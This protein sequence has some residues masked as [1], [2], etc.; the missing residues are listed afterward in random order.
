MVIKVFDLDGTLT[1]TKEEV[2]IDP[3]GMGTFSFWDLITGMLVKNYDLFHKEATNWKKNTV[4]KEKDKI[5][6][7]KKMTEKGIEFF[8]PENRSAKVVEKTAY[9]ITLKLHENGLLRSDAIYY[10]ADCLQKGEKCV[11]STASYAD[12][13]QGFLKAIFNLGLLPSN[14]PGKL[15]VS[16]NIID[17]KSGRVL[18]MNA[19][20]GKIKGLEITMREPLH[21]FKN[22]IAAVFGDD[23]YIN[24]KAI[25]ELG[26]LSFT[27]PTPKYG[28]S[29]LPH[30]CVRAS[31]EDILEN[32]E[33]LSTLHFEK[34]KAMIREPLESGMMVFFERPRLKRSLSQIHI[35][36]R[37]ADTL[38]SS[39][40]FTNFLMR[41]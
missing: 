17:W 24:D 38:Y 35:P 21:C 34:K 32:K 36:S 25:L 20:Y 9:N 13:A 40:S 26:A 31:W 3:F 12:G 39:D 8:Y 23:P 6:S 28:T 18:H 4:V 16:G 37:E 22:Q 33:C 14:H 10:L 30:N 27:I 15:I 7:S 11:I 29:K 19:E 41:K 1:T 5:A 2:S